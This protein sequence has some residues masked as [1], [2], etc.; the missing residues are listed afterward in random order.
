MSTAL[1]AHFRLGGSLHHVQLPQSTK[2]NS[3]AT[4]TYTLDEPFDKI[5]S[6]YKMRPSAETRC[7][8]WI[9]DE[10]FSKED[11]IVNLDLFPPNSVRL[12]ELM[13]IIPLKTDT[14][15]RDFQDRRPPSTQSFD[16]LRSSFSATLGITNGSAS[17]TASAD[18]YHDVDLGNRYLFAAKAMSKEMKAKHPSLEIS[19]AKHI[20]DA[21]GFKPRSNVLVTSANPAVA[22]AS[23]VELSFKDTYLARSDMWRLT[24]SEL[25]NKTVY[26]GQKI[27]FLGTIKAAVTSVYVSGKKVPSAFFSTNTKP[28]FRSKSARFVLFLQMSREMWDFD[29]EGSGEIMFTKVVNGFLPA[30]FRKWAAKKARHLVTIVL[31]TRVEYDTG[32]T[33]DLGPNALDATFH[34]GIQIDGP[35]K[36]YK[37]F[38]RVVVSEMASGEWTS[39]LYRLKR[40]FRFFR[41]D[42]SMHRLN[43]MESQIYHEEY[44]GMGS[45]PGTRIEAE[46]SLAIH[47]NILEAINLATTQFSNDYIDRDLLRTGI[48]IILISPGTGIFEVDYETLR[49]TTERLVGTGIGIDL[50]CLPKIPLH[51]VPLFRYRNPQYDAFQDGLRIKAISSEE[52][53]PRQG[54]VVGSFS[55]VRESISPSKASTSDHQHSLRSA[56]TKTA[57]DQWNS[58]IPHWLDVSFWTGASQEL[59]S[60]PGAKLPKE[61]RQREVIKPY[62]YFAVRCKMYELE[63]TGGLESGNVE[64]SVAPL[65]DELKLSFA[66]DDDD[67]EHP[68]GF[69]LLVNAKKHSSLTESTI[70]YSRLGNSLTDAE[71]SLSEVLEKYDNE[72]SVLAKPQQSSPSKAYLRN[73]VRISDEKIVKRTLAAD[74][75]VFGTSFNEADHTPKGLSLAGAAMSARNKS[76]AQ[77]HPEKQGQ[78]REGISSVLSNAASSASTLFSGRTPKLSRQISLGNRG[79]GIAAPKASVAE[80]HIENAKAAQVSK[81]LPQTTSSSVMAGHLLTSPRSDKPQNRPTS[82][83]GSL[84]SVNS[85]LPNPDKSD[86]V[87]KSRPI[88][89]KSVI[90]PERTVQKTRSIL[91]SVYERTDTSNELGN[92]AT[93]QRLQSSDSVKASKSKLFA[94]QEGPSTLSPTTALSPWLNVLNPSNPT[95]DDNAASQYKRWHHVFPKPLQ[96]KSMKWKSLSSPA[97]VPLTTEFFPT[98]LQ[99]EQEYEQ[100]PYSISQNVEEDLSE[101]PKS[102]EEFFRELISLRL[103]KGFQIVVGPAVAEA[104]G[105]KV[106]KIA[107][108]FDPEPIAEDGA[109]V[110]MASGNIIHQLSCINNTEVEIYMFSRK[111]GAHDPKINFSA[112]RYRPAIRTALDDDYFS[113]QLALHRYEDEYN[114]NYVDS[115]IAGHDEELTENLRFWRARFVLIPVQCAATNLPQLGEDTDEETRLEGIKALSQMW[116]RHRYIPPTE[117]RFQNLDSRKGKDPNPLDIVYQTSDPSVVIKTELGTL[118]IIETGEAHIRRGQLL[119]ESEPF[120]KT[121]L[122]IGALA[123][124]IQEPVGKGGVRMKD[125]RWHFRLHYNCFI[126]SDM[127]TW[128]LENFEDVETREEAVELGNLL[129]VKDEEESKKERELPREGVKEKDKDMVV[130]IFVHVEKRHLFRDGQYFYQISGD[131]AKQRPD[132]RSGWSFASRRRDS[133]IPAT[134]SVDLGTRDSPRVDRTDRSLSSSNQE[135]ETSESGN[136]TP[137]S[138]GVQRRPKVCLSKM[139]KYDVD[140]RKRSYRPERINLHYDRLHNPDNCY[141]IRIDWLNTTAKLIEDAIESWALTAERFGLRLVEVPVAEASSITDLH[142]FR[143]PYVVKL[144]RRPPDN[145]PPTYYDATSLMPQMTATKHFYQK[146]LLKK[147]DFVLDVEAEQNFPTNVEV[148]YSWG[149]PEYKYTQYIHRS[150]VLVAQITDDGNFLLLSNKLYSNRTVSARDVEKPLRSGHPL[151]DR[152]LD[153]GT[154]LV[155]ASSFGH[156]Q[157]TPIASPM[158]RATMGSP[159]SPMVRGTA[160][161]LGP[162]LREPRKNPAVLTPGSITED[163]ECFCSDEARLESFYREVLTTPPTATP[164]LRSS[165]HSSLDMNIPSLG[166]PPGILSRDISPIQALNLSVTPIRK[167]SGHPSDTGSSSVHDSPRPSVSSG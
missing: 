70:G 83:H 9:H 35:R 81:A 133:S 58:A 80:L 76:T 87:E 100:K 129:M 30:L 15:V 98:K 111:V 155:S 43:T 79:F 24:V 84:R 78:R 27:V 36:P 115:F 3:D 1:P 125:R 50:V 139:M 128:L 144:A 166:L 151:A 118:P 159:R 19:I 14:G 123:E 66:S 158:L 104:F 51:S 33:T 142:P 52:N 72:K 5:S 45:I 86:E 69:H 90:P 7:L 29:S 31:F 165:M 34:T 32:L 92:V 157:P 109:S 47:G 121:N 38:Y 116:Q 117:R 48:S 110:F 148:M 41:H 102:R 94:H 59:L 53:T 13:A 122:N 108:A 119:S 65:N 60:R 161:V 10:Q 163:L 135:E 40:E 54:G 153:R 124:A 93:L 105:Q 147:H 71:K 131:Y 149:K 75:E 132:T 154:K 28:V 167:T 73:L 49:S 56:T 107:N 113:K 120:R 23:H 164:I 106:M 6:T 4:P 74:P 156:A 57:P 26:K 46:P 103:S 99:L 11:V 20:A 67:D 130:G 138:T 134:P 22:T 77:T 42:I 61:Q 64:I 127:T 89:I 143:A 150:G 2:A 85:S 141:H 95:L 8:L 37:D 21:F 44:K 82:S 114:W 91:G 137:V 160:D 146:A 25:S 152:H 68:D 16:A 136:A 162:C 126:G 63:M 96:L 112:S 97:S 12:G 17:G 18:A 55:T 145:Q 88:A 39:I 140:P 101:V 62:R